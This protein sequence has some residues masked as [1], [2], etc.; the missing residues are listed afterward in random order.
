MSK[1]LCFF[2]YMSMSRHDMSAAN[3]YDISLPGFVELF[4]TSIV[5]DLTFPQILN[6]FKPLPHNFP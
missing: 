6:I 5:D 1:C 4:P 2:L 3:G